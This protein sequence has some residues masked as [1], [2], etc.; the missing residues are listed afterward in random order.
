LIAHH[1]QGLLAS[2]LSNALASLPMSELDS[3]LATLQPTT[4]RQLLDRLG[5]TLEAAELHNGFSNLMVECL[6]VLDLDEEMELATLVRST[7]V[8]GT[9]DYAGLRTLIESSPAR[10]SASALRVAAIVAAFEQPSHAR[11]CLA[12]LDSAPALHLPWPGVAHDPLV[13]SWR[14]RIRLLHTVS[15][16]GL[17]PSVGQPA[18][19]RSPQG[20]VGPGPTSAALGPP[21]VGGIDEA[22]QRADG[23]FTA[24]D[25]LLLRGALAVVGSVQ[26]AP[27]AEQLAK[28][29]E[30]FVRLNADRRSSYF[31]LGFL[32]AAGVAPSG[33]GRLQGDRL[34]WFQFGRICG[35]IHAGDEATLVTECIEH[36]RTVAELITHR[37]M[38][39]I[40]I[41]GVV[42]AMML[43]HAPIAAEMLAARVHPFHGALDLY[44]DVYWRA[45]MLVISGRS[46]E[47]EPLFAALESLPLRIHDAVAERQRHAD[48]IRRR[49][50]C[51]RSLDDFAS[52]EALLD[53]VELSD[54]DDR[55]L[56]EHHAERGLVA[57]RIRHLSHL[58]FPADDVER[59]ALRE[60]LANAEKH[61]TSAL[62][63][64]PQDLRATY[65][66]GVLATCERDHLAAAGLLERAEAGLMRDPVL[67]RTPLVVRS[68]FHR[69]IATLQL[70]ETGTDAAAVDSAVQSLREG[71]RP[72]LATVLE[73]IDALETHG[74]RHLASFVAEALAALDD[75]EPLVPTVV[76]LL[77]EDPAAL[78]APAQQL[79]TQTRLSLDARFE[80]H[81][82]TMRTA[83]RIGDEDT[84]LRTVESLDDLVTLACDVELDRRWADLLGTDAILREI[85]E[86]A[87]ADLLRAG[88]L[89]RIG[90][91][92]Q[93][94]QVIVQLYY[95]IAQ[96]SLDR[97][98][99]E[100]LLDL[101]DRLG[102]S[103]DELVA[104]RRLIRADAASPQPTQLPR[105]VRV[106]FAGGN[107]TQERYQGPIQDALT[108][109]YGSGLTLQ[110]F[111]PGWDMNWM[112]DAERIEAAM[113]TA[114]A[115]VILTY[116]RTNL[117]R[118]LRKSANVHDLVWRSCT[119]QGRASMER[120]IESAIEGVLTNGTS[121]TRP[122]DDSDERHRS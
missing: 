78:L 41:S 11:D 5:V 70:L 57:A 28:A 99:H 122:S 87:E 33:I 66:L 19:S 117:G 106:I 7:L 85:L 26:G 115:I 76:R 73:G 107:E 51:K 4:Q 114:D 34:R 71:Y 96:G 63:H 103:D 118:R 54:L 98:D 65:A 42:R 83:A 6:P 61:F 20:S 25:H 2:E 37:L 18:D 109:R 40:V 111:S 16:H 116:M 72:P 69:A 86:P 89:Q 82:A 94:R 9:V 56:A 80:L 68:R 36:R 24:V 22:L 1:D 75:L 110:W 38:G 15:T 93:A 46:A 77:P 48:L 95:R 84:H 27:S 21:S 35:L 8:P 74:S 64:D 45:R 23:L 97:Y 119:G 14:E 17:E 52:A 10:P 50:N 100:D 43:N 92:D 121:G 44:R 13:R 81:V 60:R 55:T 39:S 47:A 90:E 101:L 62:Q 67:S 79:L 112:K 29:V 113:P 108:E 31:H 58:S 32:A 3:V 102:S 59:S 49:V 12:L 30:E 104:L 120:S 88:V 105:P 53:M 91:L